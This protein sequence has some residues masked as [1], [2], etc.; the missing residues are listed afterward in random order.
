MSW[1]QELT[2]G[3]SCRKRVCS[4]WDACW[5]SYTHSPAA[6]CPRARAWCPQALESLLAEWKRSRD[7]VLLFSNSVQVSGGEGEGAGRAWAG[8][9]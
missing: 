2:D 5:Y 1:Q 9:P 8:C 7:K 6:A 3:G 4:C